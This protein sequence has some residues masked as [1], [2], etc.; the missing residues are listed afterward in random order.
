MAGLTLGCHL[1]GEHVDVV[2]EA[3][4]S[5]IDTPFG[6]HQSL[7]GPSYPAERAHASGTAILSRICPLG[8]AI[9]SE[10]TL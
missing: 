6:T 9:A 5:G 1:Q 7:F 3:V 2:E 8:G 10:K 4:R